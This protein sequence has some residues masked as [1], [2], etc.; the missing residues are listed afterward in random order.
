MRAQT[1][2]GQGHTRA[3]STPPTVRKAHTAAT[4]RASL[5]A[6]VV[7]SSFFEGRANLAARNKND[8]HSHSE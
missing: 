2:D 1:K 6:L 5:S 4:A 7:A 3:Q 8:Q